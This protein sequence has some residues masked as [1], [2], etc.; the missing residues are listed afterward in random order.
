SSAR[1]RPCTH[2]RTTPVPSLRMTAPA[3]PVSICQRA[4]RGLS[5]GAIEALYGRYSYMTAPLSRPLTAS[6]AA[7]L[8]GACRV[9]GDKSISH[10]ALI[11]GAL[12]TGRTRVSN[13]LESEDVLNTAKA[14]TALGAP[15]H[16][17]GNIWEILGRGV[18]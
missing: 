9:P 12:A 4:C 15:A 17:S 1:C 13:L 7:P 3:P 2:H 8:R 6:S 16:K 14:V 18:G 10:R 5:A 11:F